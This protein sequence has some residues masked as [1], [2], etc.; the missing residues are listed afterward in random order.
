MKKINRR[1]FLKLS[2]AGFGALL[3]PKPNSVSASYPEFP[4]GQNLGRPFYYGVEIKAKPDIN[5]ATVKTL[6]D[7]GMAGDPEQIV[8]LYREVMGSSDT[9]LYRSR[10]W[11]ETDGGYIYAP[12]IQPV[13]NIENLPLT[14]LPSYGEAPGF[15]AEV[16]VPYV[17]LTLDGA[18][19]KSPLLIELMALPYPPRFYYSQVLWI[20]GIRTLDDGTVQ[21]HV[22]EKHGSYGDKFWADAR[23]FQ[24]ILPEDLAP[25]DPDVPDKKIIVDVTHQSLS[26]YEG[27]REVFYATVSTGALSNADGQ[28]VTGWSTPIGDYHVVNRKY[29]SL[30]MAGGNTSAS[31]YEDFAVAYSSIFATGG[32][33]FHSTYWHNAWGSPMSHGCV[34]MKPEDSKFIFRWTQPSTPYYEGVVEQHGYDGTHVQVVE[35]GNY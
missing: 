9:R 29:M 10:T 12:N 27:S 31:G 26:C 21:Y 18:A 19:P 4:A 30:H 1:D 25:I 16:T 2:A 34:N 24:Q 33:A 14:N 15:W 3:I 32:V 23:A 11:Y 17:N 28:S 7:P 5:S 20:D 35:Y 22:I 13:K 8:N 6:P